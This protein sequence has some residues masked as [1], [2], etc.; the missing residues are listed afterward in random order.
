MTGQPAPSSELVC[1]AASTDL[2]VR[3]PGLGLRTWARR[4]PAA[5][6]SVACHR[7]RAGADSLQAR[8]QETR[9]RGA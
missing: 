1:R 2:G 7:L 8:V 4:P 6:A 3:R 9:E 5:L